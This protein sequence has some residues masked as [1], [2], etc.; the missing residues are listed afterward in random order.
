MNNARVLEGE[1]QE[2]WVTVEEMGYFEKVII[3]VHGGG[4]VAM[5]SASHMTYLAKWAS[6]LKI[7]IFSIDYR[8]APTVQYPELVNDVIRSYL[9]I[10]VQLP[11]F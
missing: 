2:G 5:S 3:H 9:W 6:E 1:R 7:P 4:F 11:H 10:L 8:L